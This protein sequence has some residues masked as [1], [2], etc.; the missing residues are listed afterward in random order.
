MIDLIQAF[1]PFNEQEVK[2][3]ATLLEIIETEN[4][5]F[6][7]NPIVHMTASAW[8]L[9]KDH[10]KV[11][12]VYHKLYNSWSWL[13]GHADGNQDL[14]SVAIKEVHEESGV[15][16]VTALS[17]DIF[18]IEILTVDGHEKNGSYVGSHLHA[19][20]TFLLEADENDPLI[21]KHDENS[22]VAWFSLEDALKASTEPWF[23][24]RIYTKLNKKLEVI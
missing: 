1:K 23:I 20:V 18:S 15:T 6:R 10:T 13:G 17:N 4:I 21:I 7:S 12:M 2:D 11:L 8:V 9:N 14:L 19:N 22:D 5:Y 3:K 16:S 24:K